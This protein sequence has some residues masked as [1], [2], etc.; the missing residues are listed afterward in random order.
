MRMFRSTVGKMVAAFHEL[1]DSLTFGTGGDADPDNLNFDQVEEL[2]AAHRRLV[3]SGAVYGHERA[4]KAICRAMG[5]FT[6]SLIPTGKD[7]KTVGTYFTKARRMWMGM[8][9]VGRGR[10]PRSLR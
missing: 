3:A 1:L 9:E 6:R 2:S 10:M 8:L 7:D 5:P 4:A